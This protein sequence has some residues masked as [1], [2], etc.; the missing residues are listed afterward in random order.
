[1]TKKIVVDTNILMDD[2]E[3]IYK[4]LND[5]DQIIFA[6]TTIK[7]LDQH[8]FNKDK[9]Y[10]ARCALRSI[11]EFQVKYPDKI[12]FSS[13]DNE[14]SQNDEK[15]IEVALQNNAVLATKDVSM[16][17]MAEIKGVETKIYDGMMDDIFDPYYYVDEKD[18]YKATGEDVFSFGQEYDDGDYETLLK[19]IS[20]ITERIVIEDSWI[21]IFI[22][23]VGRQP[24][25]YAN[26]PIK[27]ILERIDNIPKYRKI[28]IDQYT[29]INAFDEYQN[30]SIYAMIEAP[31]VLLCGSYGSGKS[32][33]TTAYSLAYNDKKTYIT[34][35]NIG[36]DPRLQIG[37]LPGSAE[38]KLFQWQTGIMSSLYYIY[39]DTKGQISTKMQGG[40]TYDFVK[41][42]I[43]KKYFEMMSLETIQGA[44]FLKSDLVLLDEVQ[45]CSISILST[46]LSRFG[47]GSKLIMTGDPRQAYEIVRPAESGLLKILRVLPHKSIAYVELKYNYRSDLIEIA[48]MLQNKV[49]I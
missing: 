36:V 25:V 39:S 2:S 27:K 48:D 29:S 18:L 40:S 9:S 19:I 45:L 33:L 41:D 15:I 20:D 42:A 49:I 1:M 10:S 37:Y 14:I 17:L 8:K 26:N 38:E 34:R 5:Y 3:I 16:G 7:E 35:P 30:C 44:S 6:L 4:L 47:N 12:K 23:V 31:N 28:S 46:V 32:L 11:R 43:F 22:N 21:F 13:N 24:I